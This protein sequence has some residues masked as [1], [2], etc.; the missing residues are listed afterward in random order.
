MKKALVIVF[1]LIGL[2]ASVVSLFRNPAAVSNSAAQPWPGEMGTLKTADAR[3][4]VLEANE[5]SVKL[6]TLVNALPENKALDDFVGREITRGELTI[7]EPPE[8]PDVRAVRE[9]LSHEAVVWEREEGI[10][11]GNEMNARR[12]VHPGAHTIFSSGFGLATATG[13]TARGITR[14]EL[15]S[16][17]RPNEYRHRTRQ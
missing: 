10:G 13:K 11:G 9:L 4:P 3:W 12:T 8:L 2:V 7:G 6:T 14:T 16:P 5:A 15:Q 17:R 1:A